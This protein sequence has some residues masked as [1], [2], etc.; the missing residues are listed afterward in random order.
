MLVTTLP[1]GHHGIAKSKPKV[2]ILEIILKLE[3]E[4]TIR[5]LKT[6]KSL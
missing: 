4:T 2:S 5:L 3:Q 6:Q 1:R